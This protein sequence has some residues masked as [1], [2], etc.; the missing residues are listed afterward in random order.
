[1][2]KLELFLKQ[3]GIYTKFVNGIKEQSRNANEYFQNMGSSNLAISSAFIW[4]DNHD[5]WKKIDKDWI[6]YLQKNNDPILEMFLRENKILTAF[7][8]AYGAG[9]GEM[10]SQGSRDSSLMLQVFGTRLVINNIAPLSELH[11]KWNRFLK[12]YE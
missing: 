6:T 3:K 11:A 2:T 1:M 5:F 9:V 8:R 12:K 7:K 10:L 4:G